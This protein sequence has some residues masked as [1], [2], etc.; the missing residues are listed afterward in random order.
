MNE[1]WC[2]VLEGSLLIRYQLC[3]GTAGDLHW[4]TQSTECFHASR[5]NLRSGFTKQRVIHIFNSSFQI[6]LVCKSRGSLADQV[7]GEASTFC[8]QLPVGLEILEIVLFCRNEKCQYLQELV[9]LIVLSPHPQ[10][11][12]S[13]KELFELDHHPA[14]LSQ[15]IIQLWAI[16]ISFTCWYAPMNLPVFQA[17]SPHNPIHSSSWW[18][19]NSIE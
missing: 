9:T 11:L 13:A 4:L 17:L 14:F 5:P 10:P 3:A 1:D 8:W 16:C 19:S 12:S 7:S 2:S 15:L 6:A 18:F